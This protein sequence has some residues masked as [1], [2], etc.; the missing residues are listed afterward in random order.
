MSDAPMAEL[1]LD[2]LRETLRQA[3]YRVEAVAD[4]VATIPYLRSARGQL[5]R[6]VR[7]DNRRAGVHPL[8]RGGAVSLQFGEQIVVAPTGVAHL[9][10]RCSLRVNG[11]D[12]RR[13]GATCWRI[14]KSFHRPI[15]SERLDIA[16]DADLILGNGIALGDVLSHG[17]NVYRHLR[18]LIADARETLRDLHADDAL[19]NGSAS[20]ALLIE[21]KFLGDLAI[22]RSGLVASGKSDLSA[23][24]VRMTAA[25]C[26]WLKDVMLPD[27]ARVLRTMV[28]Q[29]GPSL[30]PGLQA[31]V[32]TES[33]P[34]HHDRPTSVGGEPS[35]VPALEPVQ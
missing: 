27:L 3:G 11:E 28:R 8:S 24:Y 9:T 16:I 2:S 26:D 6:D 17:R 22:G 21:A 20:P 1:T 5:A 30:H 14:H 33:H 15:A 32:I 31:D 29:V 34:R 4:P 18:P 10:I 13:A 35:I 23:H 25:A 19:F 12:D 7:P